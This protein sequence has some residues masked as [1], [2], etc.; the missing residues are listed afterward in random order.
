MEFSD[1]VVSLIGVTGFEPAAFW[2]Q[3]RRTSIASVSDKELTTSLTLGCTTGCTTKPQNDNATVA[4]D[5]FAK[6][7]LMI[8][9][10]PLT[11]T[12]KAEAVRRLMAAKG[13]V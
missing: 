13:T 2:S 5:D 8:A 6:A 9:T 4:S 7:L 12:E 1:V 11:D 10:L 3:T